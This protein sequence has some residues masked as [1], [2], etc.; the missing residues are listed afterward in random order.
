MPLARAVG[1]V[2]PP[3]WDELNSLLSTSDTTQRLDAEAEA[4]SRGEG[5]A[6]QNNTLRLFGSKESDIRV[7]FYRD[8]AGV[9]RASLFARS[10][11]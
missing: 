11:C 4:R 7:T 10:F 9:R 6:H 3:T 8:H 5:P 2:T 1:T